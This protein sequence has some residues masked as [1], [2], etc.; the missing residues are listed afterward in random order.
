MD[1]SSVPVSRE[2]ARFADSQKIDKV[3][4]RDREEDWAKPDVGS[5]CIMRV[6]LISNDLLV[7]KVAINHL[8]DNSKHGCE[9]R[10]VDSP[11]LM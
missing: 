2:D 8:C 11:E 6:R 7:V 3:A 5:L 10:F 9:S 1:W 4:L